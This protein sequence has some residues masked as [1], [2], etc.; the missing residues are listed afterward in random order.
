MARYYDVAIDGFLD[1]F[2]WPY[3]GTATLAVR[4]IFTV[5]SY[6]LFGNS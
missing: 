5:W 4:L 3:N 2:I 6:L 1:I